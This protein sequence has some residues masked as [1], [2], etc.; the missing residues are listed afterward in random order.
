M[1]REY[2]QQVEI[3][4]KWFKINA[5][6]VKI[7]DGIQERFTSYTGGQDLERV[8]AD[9]KNSLGMAWIVRISEVVYDE[10][11]EALEK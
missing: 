11:V 1:R 5:K 9:I 4:P 3:N 6:S 2:L 8:K 7:V 10:V